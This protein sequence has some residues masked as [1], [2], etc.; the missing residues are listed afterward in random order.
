V[1]ARRVALSGRDLALCW[2]SVAAVTDYFD[3]RIA[4]E[5]RQISGV[6]PHADPIADKLLVGGHPDGAGRRGAGERLGAL[7]GDRHHAARI[8]VAAARYAGR[9]REQSAPVTRAA[10]WKDR[11]QMGAPAP[12][13]PATARWFLHLS[14]LRF[15]DREVMLWSP[16]CS[17]GHRLGTT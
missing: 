1:V 14:F 13:S 5:R 2:C 6:R 9:A 3:G 4:R 15:G 8:L 11:V 10:K 16:A 7:P 12:C 17:P